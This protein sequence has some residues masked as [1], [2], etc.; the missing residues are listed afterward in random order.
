MFTYLK[1]VSRRSDCRWCRFYIFQKLEADLRIGVQTVLNIQ[2]KKIQIAPDSSLNG[3]NVMSN[4]WGVWEQALQCG[5]TNKEE[6]EFP[7]SSCSARTPAGTTET[8]RGR[9]SAPSAGERNHVQLD[10]QDK[11]PGRLEWHFFSALPWS[12]QMYSMIEGLKCFQ[13][14]IGLGLNV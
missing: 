14:K 11:T 7:R 3:L 8:L 13:L 10:P 6:S 5:P 12:C 2:H 9:A 4:S 1:V